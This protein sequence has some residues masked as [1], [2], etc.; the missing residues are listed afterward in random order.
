MVR[1]GEQGGFLEPVL[2]RLGLFVEQRDQLRTKVIGSMIYPV[3]LLVVGLAIVM[4]LVTY[5]M[6][7]GR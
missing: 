6:P 7:L 2:R 1:A 4:V 5:F 3:F